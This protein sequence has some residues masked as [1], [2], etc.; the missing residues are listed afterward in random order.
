MRRFN[1]VLALALTICILTSSVVGQANSNTDIGT[2]LRSED[3]ESVQEQIEEAKDNDDLTEDQKDMLVEKLTMD[4]T[5]F[6]APRATTWTY[7]RALQSGSNR[8]NTIAF[9]LV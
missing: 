6:I 7:Y 5:D 3:G 9:L 4:D 2:G 1:K 8:K